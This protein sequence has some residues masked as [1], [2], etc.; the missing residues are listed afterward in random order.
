MSA[1]KQQSIISS[2]K[3]SGSDMSKNKFEFVKA[4]EVH[5]VLWKNTWIVVRLD[6]RNFHKFA[7]KHSFN[8]P[9]DSRALDLMNRA[10][11]QVMLDLP[12]IAVAY[13]Q[14]DE[15]S[16]VIQKETTLHQRHGSKISAYI[17]SAFTASFVYYWKDYFDEVSMKTPPVFDANLQ[18]YPSVRDLRDYLSWRQSDCHLNNLYKTT[19][20]ALVQKGG[21]SIAAAEERLM[22][23][24]TA[25]KNEILFSQFGINYNNELDLYKK[26]TTLLRKSV[27]HPLQEDAKVIVVPLNV[28]LTGEAFWTK[29]TEVL[30][31][32]ICSPGDFDLTD[33]FLKS[34]LVIE[35]LNFVKIESKDQL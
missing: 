22:D 1:P 7:E 34:K 25:D 3:A 10:A 35:Q 20:W 23:S 33:E 28:D 24:T 18:L 2:V 26:G 19:F 8:K 12:D 6:G 31:D 4:F 16:F 29:N 13:G 5:D 11:V 14:S 32:N 17:S 9:N 21:L 15:Y 27:K 30:G